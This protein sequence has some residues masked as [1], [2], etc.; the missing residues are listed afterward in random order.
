MASALLEK[1][2]GWGRATPASFFCLFER[3]FRTSVRWTGCDEF[4][5]Y[6]PTMDIEA[7][8]NAINNGLGRVHLWLKEHP[9]QPY[10]EAIRHVCLHNTAYDRQCERSRAEYVYEIIRLTNAPEYF[11]E[12]I[13][14]GLLASKDFGDT[15]HLYH[16]ARLLAQDGNA[17]AREAMYAKFKQDDAEDHFV[18]ADQI[19]RLDGITG[20]F[21]VLERIGRWSKTHPEY[22][23]D[24]S[25]LS[26]AKEV[27]GDEVMAQVAQAAQ[28][29]PDI[30]RYMALYERWE[31][32]D[33][34]RTPTASV[35]KNWT[36]AELRQRI[37]EKPSDVPRHWLFIWGRNAAEDSLREAA[38]DVMQESD[39]ERLLAYLRIF[40][41]SRFPLDPQ[42]LIELAADDNTEIATASRRALQHIQHDSVRLYAMKVIE[43]G[44][45]DGDVVRLLALN[46]AAGDERVIESLLIAQTD[47]DE[48]HWMCHAA[49]KVFEANVGAELLPSL[50]QVY[51]RCR[52]SI[53]RAEAV[54][55][56]MARKLIP[57]WMAEECRYD[58]SEDIRKAVAQGAKGG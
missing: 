58:S 35:W 47:E 55:V 23:E 50:L 39:P 28:T 54:E 6:N 11:A 57:E 9:W 38:A 2:R 12:I 52:C 26:E 40:A 5:D 22:W 10:A 31:R 41:R 16:L 3:R 48:L 8:T 45:G 18:G 43:Q 36:Y 33:K 56:L 19:F 29:N 53:C 49:V 21:F 42:R 51:E 25:L 17:A 32:E 4:H 7:F 44:K 1:G 15:C 46:Y 13:T 14:M 24:Y 20:L 34:E 27:L 37:V 30:G